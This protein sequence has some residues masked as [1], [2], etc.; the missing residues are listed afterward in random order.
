MTYS[1]TNPS[2]YNKEGGKSCIEEMQEH[3]GVIAVIVFCIVIAHKYSYR[4]GKKQDE[5]Y[6]DDIAKSFWYYNKADELYKKLPWYKQ[7]LIC[8][9]FPEVCELI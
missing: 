7:F 8:L 4:A 2:Y 9:V 6:G 5:S 3:F 1:K